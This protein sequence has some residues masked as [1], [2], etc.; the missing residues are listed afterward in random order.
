MA[1]TITVTMNSISDQG[2]GESI[3]TI[4]AQ[5]G[6]DGLVIRPS[7]QGLR[8]GSMGFTSTPVHHAKSL[9]TVTKSL[10]QASQPSATGIQIK[11]TH[12]RD[13]SAKGIEVI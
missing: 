3:G 11:P 5:D 6:P 1:D 8:E 12:T 2:I 4:E 7:L 9:A 13:L 10:L